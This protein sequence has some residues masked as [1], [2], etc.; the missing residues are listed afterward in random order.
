MP[1]KKRFE[2]TGNKR[3]IDWNDYITQVS[4]RP[5]QP[6]KEM[7]TDRGYLDEK[8]KDS[9]IVSVRYDVRYVAWWLNN[10]VLN[11][12]D[13][14]KNELIDIISGT[15]EVSK[16]SASKL[17]NLQ[18]FDTNIP[19]LGKATFAGFFQFL[20]E[21]TK[22]GRFWM[23]FDNLNDRCLFLT[24]NTEPGRLVVPSNQ[25][26]GVNRF[27]AWRDSMDKYYQLKHLLLTEKIV[28]SFES[29]CYR[30]D[31]SFAHIQKT[32]YLI[33][34]L[35]G[36]QCRASVSEGWELLRPAPTWEEKPSDVVEEKI[37]R[38]VRNEDID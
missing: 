10:F 20:A 14:D 28:P 34:G 13:I 21:E 1:R 11:R 19:G 2:K 3:V 27:D 25:Y 5:L 7:L 24:D 6:R 18:P 9:D 17:M 30:L 33:E 29:N 16:T 35:W 15:F 32:Y 8:A 31:N 12:L 26:I 37:P 23:V 38:T 22:A 36:T 4:R